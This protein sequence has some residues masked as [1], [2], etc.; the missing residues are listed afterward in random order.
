MSQR[1]WYKRRKGQR[2][3]EGLGREERAGSQGSQEGVGVW[4]VGEGHQSPIL[5]PVCCPAGRQAGSG[6][7][8]WHGKLLTRSRPKAW[9]RTISCSSFFLMYSAERTMPWVRR[10]P[11]RGHGKGRGPSGDRQNLRDAKP[12]NAVPPVPPLVLITTWPGGPV[13]FRHSTSI[14]QMGRRRREE[15]MRV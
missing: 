6:Q 3:G 15:G 12:A 4:P 7:G 14:A 11:R 2:W 10:E 5:P 8:S 13:A 9:D 1:S